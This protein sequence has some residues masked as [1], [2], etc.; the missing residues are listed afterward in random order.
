MELISVRPAP[1]HGP[2]MPRKTLPRLRSVTI[3]GKAIH[4]ITHLF[5]PVILPVR[6]ALDEHA[7]G[8]FVKGESLHA[9]NGKS[10]CLFASYGSKRIARA[11]PRAVQNQYAVGCPAIHTQIRS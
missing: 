1:H 5:R 11:G 8:S 6:A 7:A 2:P 3:K 9:S 10:K 4:T